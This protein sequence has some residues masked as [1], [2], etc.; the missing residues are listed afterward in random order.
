VSL[1]DKLDDPNKKVGNK[2]FASKAACE[3]KAKFAAV[4][5]YMEAK[6][7]HRKYKVTILPYKCKHCSQWHVGKPWTGQG[8]KIKP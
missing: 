8:G 2:P 6:R 7:L 1:S 4:P 3:R 5:A